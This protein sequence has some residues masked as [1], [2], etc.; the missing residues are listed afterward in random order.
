MTRSIAMA[1]GRHADSAMQL[2]SNLPAVAASVA[3][4]RGE[5]AALAAGAGASQEQVDRVRLAVSEAVTNVIEHAYG[6]GAYGRI[7]MAAAVE[8][9]E[10]LVL[11]SDEG[12]GIDSRRD[13]LGLGL[14]L[15]LMAE[16][17]DGLTISARSSGGVD[18]QMRFEVGAPA[19]PARAQPRGSS[20]AAW[21]PAVP[22][23]STTT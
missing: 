9:G 15:G 8:A 2:S 7:H 13:S 16:A 17:C 3:C 21:R 12:G 10:L 19:A 20:R 4:M 5:A 18:V 22:R 23:F 11:V 6:G 14:G 1:T